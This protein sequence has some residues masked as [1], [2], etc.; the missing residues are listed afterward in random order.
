MTIPPF[1][2]R[3]EAGRIYGRGS[4]DMKGGVAAI[5]AAAAELARERATG[6]PL[7]GTLRLALV[8]DEELTSLGADHF[9]ANH[10]ADGC[11]LAESTAGQLILAHKGFVWATVRTAGR[12]AHG[13]RWDLGRSAIGAMG[14]VIAALEEHDARELRA[15]THPLVGPASMHCALIQGGVGVSTYAPECTL[16]IERRTL[17]EEAPESVLAELRRVVAEA[18]EAAEVTL[19]LARPAM[20]CEPQSPLARTVRDAA[21]AITG[22]RPEHAG[23]GYW[24]D[25]AVFSAAG[26]PSLI[27]GPTGE[28]AHEA[29]E[30][31]DT[32]SVVRC[33]EIYAEAARR[34]CSKQPS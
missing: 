11:I 27:Y 7:A 26:I 10:P 15:R 5:L 32:D 6:K 33:A 28:G 4:F 16:R 30:W 19:D 12:A 9:A 25:A 22:A 1:E 21:Q 3:A 31:V 14:R 20:L 8:A 23:V 2:P 24:T 34:F 13:S 29:V 17:P 18:G